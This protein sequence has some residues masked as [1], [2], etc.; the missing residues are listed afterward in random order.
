MRLLTPTQTRLIKLVQDGHVAREIER[1]EEARWLA[2]DD[3]GL[4]LLTGLLGRLQDEVERAEKA[5]GPEPDDT[6]AAEAV[7]RFNEMI[8]Q[9]NELLEALERMVE[10]EGDEEAGVQR[11]CVAQSAVKPR[12]EAERPPPSSKPSPASSRVQRRAPSPAV[13]DLDGVKFGVVERWD[14]RSWSGT[15]SW[16]GEEVHI[17]TRAL[18]RAGI[19]NLSIGQKCE[20]QIVV[21]SDGRKEAEGLKLV[22]EERALAGRVV[23]GNAGRGR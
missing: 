15:L 2:A 19:T 16:A 11:R 22:H 5:G 21:G 1:R 9:V 4:M 12:L 8:G 3:D 18:R 23:N 10:R 20:F 13:L 6:E 7:A 17:P 14:H